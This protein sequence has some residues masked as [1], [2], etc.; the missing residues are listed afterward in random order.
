VKDADHTATYETAKRVVDRAQEI[1]ELKYKVGAEGSGFRV[2]GC[3]FRL[4]RSGFRPERL[5]L[6][7]WSQG[8][9]F[10]V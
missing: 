4:Q 3:G 7:V 9:G 2:Q 8:Y 10:R 1:A 6:W 5:A